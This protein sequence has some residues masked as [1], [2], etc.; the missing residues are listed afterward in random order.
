MKQLLLSILFLLTALSS[1]ATHNRAGEISYE[2]IGPNQFKITLVTYTR[3]ESDADRPFIEI[4]WGD[5]NLDSLDRETGYPEV[6]DDD[7]HKNVYIG[8][9]TFP[10]PGNYTISLED[11]NRNEGVSNIPNSINVPFYIESNIL[12]NP[13]LGNNHS[14]VLLNPP[15]DDAC[16][17]SPYIHNPSAFDADG[18]SLVYKLVDPKGEDGEVIDGYFSPS[19]V[20]INSQTGTMTWVNPDTEG[21]F[22]FAILVEEYRNGFLIGSLVRDMQI[23]VSKC[24]NHPPVIQPFQNICIEAGEIIN[25]E[26]KATDPDSADVITL[27]ASG[28]PISEVA[29]NLASFPNGIVG[30]DSVSGNF[31]WAT[32]C[33]HVRLNPY[34][35]IFKAEDNDPTVSLIDLATINIT[36][37]GPETPNLTSE[38]TIKGIEL[39]WDSN[40]CFGV[41]GYKIYRKIDSTLWEHDTCETGVPQY[42]GFEYLATNSGINATSFTDST[43]I[44]G[45]K[46][47]YRIV[48]CFPDGAE[49]YSSLEVCSEPFE[50]SP[51]PT[52]VDVI[53]TDPNS[54]SIYVQWNNPKDIDSLQNSGPFMYKVYQTINGAS[55]L[56]YTS[57]GLN[58]TS[59]TITNINTF[60]DQ[61][62]FFIELISTS[63]GSEVVA[64][65]SE[66]A[67]SIYLN[68]QEGDEKLILTWQGNTPWSK[69]TFVVL[70]ETSPGSGIFNALD[71]ITSYSYT[72]LGLINGNTYCYKILSWG[73]YTAHHFDVPFLNNSQVKCAI[74]EDI[75]PPCIPAVV[76]ESNC[77]NGENKFA[78]DIDSADCLLDLQTLSIHYKPNLNTTYSLLTTIISPRTDSTFTQSNLSSVAGCYSF[79]ATDSSGNESAIGQEVCFDNCPYYQIPNLFTPNDDGKND[80]LVPFPYQ[81]IESIELIIYNR[82]GQQVY[83]TNNIDIQW[84]GRNQFTNLKSSSGVY[85]YKCSVEEI[86]MNGNETK[87][88]NGFIQVVN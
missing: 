19:D 3:I 60:E 82:W 36:V 41:I 73:Y 50:L 70:K 13:F 44:E 51:I 74:P 28:G 66:I 34:Q 26:I 2:Q 38:A 63:T 64:S 81:Y 83:K 23:T 71:T 69:D 72:D 53:D 42:T 75:I 84:D 11:P 78:W 8:I 45:N 52:H 65:T 20:S 85:F 39:N 6:V 30:I 55:T 24:S 31:D 1:W 10:G 80:E 7:I 40:P 17:E 37:I 76:A 87:I 54:G 29:G 21:E 9:H 67:N 59:C 58:D 33:P 22:N 18:D 62:S 5:G 77:I 4:N 25:L 27:T 48:A 57:A 49:S 14:P 88:I 79:S 16:I 43:A 32:Q 35:V 68:I 12:I 15:I 47:C 46:Y 86:R 61:H 56:V